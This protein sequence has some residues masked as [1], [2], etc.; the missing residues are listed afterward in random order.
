MSAVG[1][2]YNDT[3]KRLR[4]RLSYLASLHDIDPKALDFAFINCFKLLDPEL[5]K[6]YAPGL[7]EVKLPDPKPVTKVRAKDEIRGSARISKDKVMV[8]AKSKGA[9][10]PAIDLINHIYVY[11]PQR[12]IGADFLSV[13]MLLETGWGNYTGDSKPYNPAGIKKAGQQA[14]VPLAFEVPSTPNEGAR[15]LINH[16]CAVLGLDPI[17]FPMEDTKRQRKFMLPDQKSPKFLNLV[18]V[19]GLWTPTMVTK[20]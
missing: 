12:N 4:G 14:D 8:F 5:S 1:T 19:I 11:A 2:D 20:L 10:Q 16:W 6:E 13:Q 3:L 9:K 15:M 18:V 17:G 7:G